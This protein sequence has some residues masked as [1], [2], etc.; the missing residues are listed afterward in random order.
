[1]FWR[2]SSSTISGRPPEKP[3]LG[4]ASLL[5]RA[6]RLGV[7]QSLT[8]SFF[9]YV[10]GMGLFLSV[11]PIIGML[12]SFFRLMARGDCLWD[13][14]DEIA[15]RKLP[16]ELWQDNDGGLFVFRHPTAT[17]PL[18]IH[19]SQLFHRPDCSRALGTAY[20][21]CSLH[22]RGLASLCDCRNASSVVGND[23]SPS[24]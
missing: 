9:V 22:G 3:S 8:R 6:K 1:M 13:H 20:G 5:S 15:G 7:A 2:H 24:G 19:E 18:I 23:V 10:F 21:D 14:T 12:F 16:F 17:S 11:L 4:S